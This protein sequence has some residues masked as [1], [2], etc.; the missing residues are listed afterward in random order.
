MSDN[1]ESH[2]RENS[3]ELRRIDQTIDLT[4]ISKEPWSD[5]KTDNHG[6]AAYQFGRLLNCFNWLIGWDLCNGGNVCRDEIHFVVSRLLK[7]ADLFESHE[8]H[9][10]IDRAY[11]WWK[12]YLHSEEFGARGDELAPDAG[13]DWDNESSN[14]ILSCLQE[15]LNV[16]G[17]AAVELGRRIDQGLR[18]LSMNGDEVKRLV[19]PKRA[20]LGDLSLSPI[21]FNSVEL[22]A[23]KLGLSVPAELSQHGSDVPAKVAAVDRCVRDQLPT[24]EHIINVRKRTKWTIGYLDLKICEQQQSVGRNG[25]T[26]V[27]LSPLSFQL[28]LILE[29]ANQNYASEKV[30]AE[31][32]RSTERKPTRHTITDAIS[33]LRKCLKEL[34]IDITSK[35]KHGWQ[36][37]QSPNFSKD[38]E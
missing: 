22:L 38:K 34:G 15:E 16:V 13:V 24:K 29:Q 26:N 20:A 21:W 5:Q 8:T 27:T 2:D 6:L 4:S 31:A 19:Y 28:L 10:A 7:L 37:I 17:R 23:G 12:A 36:L 11:E 1:S 30:L 33:D 18:P 35:R 25:Y 3:A 14:A 9:Q 32:W